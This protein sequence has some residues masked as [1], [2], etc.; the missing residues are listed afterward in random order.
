MGSRINHV[1]N[2]IGTKN[3]LK[4]NLMRDSHNGITHISS[5]KSDNLKLEK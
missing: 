3:H 5:Q 4:L 1:L 2:T